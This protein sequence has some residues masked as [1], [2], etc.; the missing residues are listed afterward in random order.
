MNSMRMLRWTGGIGGVS[1][2]EDHWETREEALTCYM[3]GIMTRA[4]NMESGAGVYRTP[5]QKI[6]VIMQRGE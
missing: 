1:G 2:E 3:E 4:K 5:G 6:R